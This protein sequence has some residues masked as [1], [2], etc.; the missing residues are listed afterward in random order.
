MIGSSVHSG[1]L[2]THVPLDL[3]SGQGALINCAGHVADGDAFVALVDRLV[4]GLESLPV[5][6]Q[7]V[8]WLL[9][10]PRCSISVRRGDA[11]SNYQR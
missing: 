10:E 2:S 1:D 11:A 8:C 3:I 6:E 9:R 7:P 5:E 4:T